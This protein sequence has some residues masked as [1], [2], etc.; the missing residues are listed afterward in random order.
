MAPN[1][2]NRRQKRQN[3]AAR[4][5]QPPPLSG[6]IMITKTFRFVQVA[7]LNPAAP[8]SVTSA[9]LRDVLCVCTAAGV[10]GHSLISRLRLKKVEA[11]GPPNVAGTNTL[12]IIKT[13][14]YVDSVGDLI[15]LGSPTKRVSDTTLGTALPAHIATTFSYAAADQGWQVGSPTTGFWEYFRIDSSLAGTIWDLTIQFYLCVGDTNDAAASVAGAAMPT[16]VL[17]QQYVRGFDSA[18][19]AAT[20]FTPIGW[21]VPV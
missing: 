17:G 5:L 2:R 14:L 7:A 1:S 13:G 19:L 16:G 15:G 20:N 9:N 12:S 8:H 3:Q 18:T 10:S 11:W 21:G 6:S 4:L